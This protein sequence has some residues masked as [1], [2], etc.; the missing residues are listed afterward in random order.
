MSKESVLEELKSPRWH[1]TFFTAT[2]IPTK[3]NGVL[4]PQSKEVHDP[5]CLGCEIIALI[6]GEK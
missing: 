6:N 4:M 2:S 1:S 3:V 5:F